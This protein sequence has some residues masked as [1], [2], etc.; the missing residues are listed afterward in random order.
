MAGATGHKTYTYTVSDSLATNLAALVTLAEK[1]GVDIT[2]AMGVT[3]VLA[4]ESTRTITSGAM[5]CFTYLPVAS[6]G[7][8]EP[9]SWLW[10]PYNNGD[11]DSVTST[12]VNRCFPFGDRLA[13]TGV[14]RIAWLPDGLVVSAG[15][16][17]TLTYTVRRRR[18]S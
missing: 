8:G 6:N 5:R 10:M 2:H 13:L 12:V 1:G 9:T 16:T 3:A 15:T 11:V 4:A 7:S 14:G 18:G 17:V